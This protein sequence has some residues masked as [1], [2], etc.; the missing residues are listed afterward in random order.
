MH[1]IDKDYLHHAERAS[2]AVVRA[3]IWG[4][5]AI[6]VLGATLFDLGVIAF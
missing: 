5:L 4:G 3:L 2:E 1:V 6:C